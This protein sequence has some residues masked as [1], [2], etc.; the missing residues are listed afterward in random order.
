MQT[1]LECL[2]CFLIQALSAMRMARPGEDALH[3]RFM[4]E[5]MLRS[6]RESLD[7]APPALAGI[8]YAMLAE[9][10]GCDDPFAQR[11]AQANKKVLSLLDGLR[12]RRDSSE[13]PL[14]TALEM[15]IIG[16]YIDYGV[17]RI[18]DWEGELAE[19]ASCLEPEP[20]S[21]FERAAYPGADILILG[22]NAGEIALDLLLV[23]SLL[24]RGCRVTYAVR[25]R[26]VINDATLEDAE[27]VGMTELCDVVSSGVD[28]PGTIPQRC[29]PGFLH[30]MDQVDLILSKG[31]GNFESLV[32]RRD[33]VAFAFKVK[34]PVAER[35]TGR[36]VGSSVFTMPADQ[37]RSGV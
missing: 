13:N 11:K 32:D 6:A 30:R 25:E 21:R 17:N 7:Q 34:C 3:A 26:P 37:N 23:E 18:F 2:P 29:S 31:Q 19:L 1:H 27:A 28:T 5:W 36:P 14:A 15:A 4:K 24:K 9:H 22:D 12:T 20:L 33:D 35:L 10:I 16:N 8:M